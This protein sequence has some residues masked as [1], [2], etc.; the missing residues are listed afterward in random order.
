MST[1]PFEDD[2]GTF[3]LLVNALHPVPADG[4]CAT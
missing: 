4:V 3:F 1:N 2:N